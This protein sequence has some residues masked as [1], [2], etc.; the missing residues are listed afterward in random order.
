[1]SA[2]TLPRT[3]LTRGE[4]LLL[5]RIHRWGRQ[6]LPS[7]HSYLPQW[8]RELAMPPGCWQRNT[9]PAQPETCT[10]WWGPANRGQL[11][12][13]IRA[14]RYGNELLDVSYEP[15]SVREAVDV[16]VALG[17]LPADLSSAY[18]VGYLGGLRRKGINARGQRGVDG[19]TAASATIGRT[20]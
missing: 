2:P 1:M 17:V 15:R 10:V 6:P 19:H 14:S 4:R 11:R 5:A 7:P 9:T 13:Q 12:V 3:V 16:L 8:E 18:L 20:R